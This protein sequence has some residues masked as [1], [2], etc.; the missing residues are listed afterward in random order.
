LYFRNAIA[1]QNTETEDQQ[2]AK[3]AA[4]VVKVYSKVMRDF[5][6]VDEVH[7]STKKALLNFSYN[8]TL[9]KLDEAYRAVKAI[10][11]PAIWENMAQ[12]CVK[13]KRLDVAEVCLGNMGHA[14]GAA[15]LR[16]ARKSGNLEVSVGVLAIQLGLLDDA[17]RLFREGNRYD[18]LNTLYQSAGLWDKAI[19]TATS[20]DR[21]HLKTTHYQFAKHL[22]SI[23]RIDDAI[24][25]FQLSDNSRT[26]VP[27]MLF[28]LGRIDDLGEYVLKSDDPVLL[29]WWAAYLESIE[30]YDKAKKFYAKA[31]D[32]L[33]LVRIYCFKGDF[34]KAAD[35]VSETGDRASAYHF[36]RQLEN[37]GDFKEAITF[38][39]QS[40]C[41]NHSIRLAREHGMDGELMRFALKSTPSLMVE[42]GVH[43][44]E[45]GEFDKAVQLY[46]KGGDIPRALDLCFRTTEGTNDKSGQSQLMFDMLNT[47]AQ[48]LGDDTS[49]QT[50]ARCAE[51]L[52]QHKQ[53]DKAIDLYVK[54]GR[55]RSAI[56]MCQQFKVTVNEEMV[57]KLT[58]PDSMEKAE[59]KE[60]LLDLA[61]VLKKQESYLLAYKKYTQAG[62][63][64]QAIKCLVRSGNTKA[65]IEFA[66]ISKSPEVYKIAANYLQQMNWRENGVIMKS[67]IQFYT[68]AKAFVQLAGFYDSCAQVEIDEYS[69][70]DKATSA[71]KEG[72]KY[73][74]K[75]TSSQGEGMAEAVDRRIA[76]IERFI[77]AKKTLKAD[78]STAIGI[79]EDLLADP[80]LEEA[81]RAGDCLALLVEYFHGVGQ[82]PEA[83]KYLREMESRNIALQPYLEPPVIDDIMRAFPKDKG[84]GSSSRGKQRSPVDEE[85]TE[86]D[87]VMPRG[88][89]T[90]ELKI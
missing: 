39:A 47:I 33:S 49:P 72:L 48:D 24:E 74:R 60:V 67:I 54:A 7:D 75:D 70:Y 69:D 32:Y 21:I 51:F 5:I 35:I 15:A 27:R 57:D 37:Q 76:M 58:P 85:E 8:L 1:T 86:E 80:H 42:C 46:H 43:F 31:N 63:R 30:R 53:F 29:K 20:K 50:L 82:L 9:G 2:N 59:R 56:E 18:M 45:R 6:G 78:P 16:E 19:L 66:K 88:A 26:E 11:S 22:E 64:L 89:N 17:A 13:T 38:Y 77:Q 81:V 83:Y 36:A 90:L 87:Y 40:G 34:N 23:G 4:N 62:D 65:V 3:Q 68:L 61:K 41:Y 73:L 10:D 52:V 79:C 14:R 71:L 12:M 55:Y 28:H 44:E 84:V 25:H